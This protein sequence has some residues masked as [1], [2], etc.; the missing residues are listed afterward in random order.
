MTVEQ[1]A[2]RYK[3]R[4][5]VSRWLRMACGVWVRGD[6]AAI[7]PW[8]WDGLATDSRITPGAPVVIAMDLAFSGG[9]GDEP[10]DTTALAPHHWTTN[11]PNTARR[12]V[13]DPI[14]L[15]PPS[16]DG[17]L[18]DRAVDW[19]LDVMAGWR[20]FDRDAFELELA[21][22]ND[23]Y[24]VERWADAIEACPGYTATV[25]VYDPNA[26]AEQLVNAKRRAHKGVL[27]AEFE[28][29]PS[30][31][32][33][34]DGRLMEA[35]RQKQLEHTGHEGLR[36]HALNATEKPVGEAFYF[37]HPRR[38]RKPQDA[39][40]AAS[41]AHDISVGQGGTGKVRS[42]ARIHFA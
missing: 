30:N 40:R 23:P 10:T 33:R 18:D 24:D 13:G 5:T 6:D 28:Q 22:E 4:S 17:R 38:P 29:K 35:L 31:M 11:D 37:D 16:G 12:L 36:R 26:G 8:E 2:R 20:R 19:A 7:K 9:N 14:I 21:D 3:S 15:E 41:M 32:C 25:V 1:L 39:L 27:F 34:A 42:G